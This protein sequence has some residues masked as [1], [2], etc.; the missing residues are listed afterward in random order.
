MT[1]IVLID[2][3]SMT[4]SEQTVELDLKELYRLIDCKSVEG[5]GWREHFCYCD[6]TGLYHSPPL[7]KVWFRDA[8]HP[9]AGWIVV[10]GLPDLEG[11]ETDCLA[12]C[13]E[14]ESWIQGYVKAT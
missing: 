12:S 6:G 8:K 9:V 5:F 2:P 4:V 11:N 1:R 13:S 10:T 7:P 14:V 3:N